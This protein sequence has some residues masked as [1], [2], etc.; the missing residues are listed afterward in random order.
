MFSLLFRG[1]NCAKTAAAQGG[2]CYGSGLGSL[3]NRIFPENSLLAGNSRRDGC[4]QHCLASHLFKRSAG[5]PKRREKGPGFRAFR[6]FD[7]VSRPPIR[8]SQGGNRRKSPTL[9]AN[10]PVLQRLSA[11]TVLITTAAR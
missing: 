6:V 5:F 11:E 9:S 2:L 8:R 4:D 10:I 7:F 3:E 1:G